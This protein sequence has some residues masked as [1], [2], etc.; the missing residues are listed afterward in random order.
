MASKALIYIVDDEPLQRELLADHLGNMPAYEIHSFGTGE[1]CLAAI[2]VRIPTIVF[3]D[4]YLNSQVKDAMDGTE[5]LQEIKSIAPAIE[6]VMISGQDKIEVAVNSMKH[7]AFDYIVKGE[8]AFVRA[9]KTVFNIYRFHKLTG[10]ASRYRT[11]MVLF[12]I[13]MLLMIILVIYLQTHGY[14]SKLPGWA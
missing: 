12:G 14:I 11:L 3:L 13:G 10:T 2:K 7:G 1:E 6:V 9:E 4:Y 5:I 8:G